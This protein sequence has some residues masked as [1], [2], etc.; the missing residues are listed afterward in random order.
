M[1]LVEVEK[2]GAWRCLSNPRQQQ[3]VASLGGVDVL[4]KQL[5]EFPVALKDNHRSKVLRGQ[6]GTKQ[7]IAKQSH[8]KNNRL[9]ARFLSYFEPCDAAQTL[10]SLERFHDVGLPSVE[11]LFVLEKRALGAVVDSWLCYEYREGRFCDDECLPRIVEL[12]SEMHRLGFRHNDPNL[13]NFLVDHNDDLFM[14]DTKGRAR[15]GVFSDANDFFL[16]KKVNPHLAHFELEDVAHLDQLSFG[17]RLASFYNGLKS[18][19]SK[20][21]DK[22][23]K[24]RLKNNSR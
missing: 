1:M 21:K 3:W 6:L 14:L 7:V 16:L 10:L 18:L 15:R 17:Y 20:I 24:N 19:R 23:K 8:D 2:R 5:A 12:L 22:T 9:W 4:L 11:P 13:G